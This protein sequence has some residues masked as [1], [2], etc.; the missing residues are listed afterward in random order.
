MS[1]AVRAL[2][3]AMLAD[4]R[5]DLA[6]DQAKIARGE[7][8]IAQLIALIALLDGSGSDRDQLINAKAAGAPR[9][10]WNRDARSGKLRAKKLGREFLATRGDVA[11]WL[12][13]MAS[14]VA[15]P[16]NIKAEAA[17]PADAFERARSR[18]RD[19]RVA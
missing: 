4:A 11:D 5:A 14:P 3:V 17:E 16:A 18:A 8:R 1:A 13:G 10:P 2:A 15:P 12:A 6:V 19:R 9:G 7:A